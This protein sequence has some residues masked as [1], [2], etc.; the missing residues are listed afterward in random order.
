MLLGKLKLG[1]NVRNKL[2]ARTASWGVGPGMW[3]SR[4]SGHVDGEAMSLEC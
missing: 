2:P 4:G 1:G 3:E